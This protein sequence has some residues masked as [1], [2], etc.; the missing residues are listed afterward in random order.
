MRDVYAL[1]SELACER[2]CQ[3]AHG[4]FSGREGGEVGA[5]AHGGCGGGEDEGWW[6]FGVGVQVVEEEGEGVLGEVVGS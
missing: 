1:W 6:V 3:G 5:A 2:L 4:E